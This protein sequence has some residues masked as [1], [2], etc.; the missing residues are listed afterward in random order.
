MEN[1]KRFQ[2]PTNQ[3][4]VY[5]SAALLFEMI[6]NDEIPVDKAEQANQALN[7]MNRTVAIEIKLAE[8]KKAN[9]IRQIEPKNFE[10]QKSI[11]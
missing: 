10:E 9:E 2:K 5:A 3:K 11:V 1:P 4:S 7:I 6:M 8:L